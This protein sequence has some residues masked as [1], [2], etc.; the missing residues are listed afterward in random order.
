MQYIELQQ[1]LKDFT[2]FSLTDIRKLEPN[3]DRR[4]LN[5]W[6]DKGYIKK[7]RRG[8][9]I[10]ADI[11]VDDY[12]LFF[13]ANKL[14]TPSYI[15]FEMA[16]SYYNLIPEG[17]HVI[18]SASSRKKIEFQ[19]PVGIFSYQQL[20]PELMFGYHL[21]KHGKQNYKLAD[22]E[23]AVLDY[24]YL[25]PHVTNLADLHEWRFNGEEFLA[26]AD[27]HKF[28]RYVKVF[29]SKSLEKRAKEL[30]NFIKQE[31]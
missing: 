19:T 5:E 23:K 10:F 28:N 16:L 11:T 18:T 17:V 15:S 21:E 7:L 1:K 6:Q 13:I 25:Y 4:R 2:V 20:K 27:I 26:T 22:I 3:F 24:L 8:Y 12:S 9:Y 29:N 14:Y 30:L 31:L